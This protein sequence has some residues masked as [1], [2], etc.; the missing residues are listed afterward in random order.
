MQNSEW[1]T[2]RLWFH[3]V[4]IKSQ[5]FQSLYSLESG[6]DPRSDW[7]VFRDLRSH[8]ASTLTH[9]RASVWSLLLFLSD[10]EINLCQDS[11]QFGTNRSR[12]VNTRPAQD[13]VCVLKINWSVLYFSDRCLKGR[14]TCSAV[15][16]SFTQTHAWYSYAISSAIIL[17]LLFKQRVNWQY[18]VCL[19]LYKNTS[20]VHAYTS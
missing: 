12:S 6:F 17:L 14:C 9:V 15:Q 10:G 4:L 1:F 3:K 16:S 13:K 5:C 8:T 11:P 2:C 20:R 19:S 18:R 7:S